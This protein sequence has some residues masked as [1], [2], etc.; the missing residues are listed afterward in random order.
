MLLQD[1]DDEGTIFGID[2][3]NITYVCETGSVNRSDR[4]T[5]AEPL[6]S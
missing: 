2:Q 5:A 6:L 4:N 3:L 1:C